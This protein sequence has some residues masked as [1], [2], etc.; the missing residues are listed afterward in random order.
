MLDLFELLSL[1]SIH[2][3]TYV[4]LLFSVQLRVNEQVR[5]MN[6]NMRKK[7]EIEEIRLVTGWH[8]S[9]R[10]C[11]FLSFTADNCTYFVSSF[12][13][14]FSYCIFII[15]TCVFNYAFTALCMELINRKIMRK[16]AFIWRPFWRF[17]ASGFPALSPEV[18]DGVTLT[19]SF[20]LKQAKFSLLKWLLE[21][22]VSTLAR[23]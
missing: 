14:E 2:F 10:F 20:G 23:D 5:Y 12:P 17:R 16:L 6:E 4:C 18:G 8:A 21:Q 22:L 9:N 15:K 3:L 7:R 11:C 13:R 19:F 1:L